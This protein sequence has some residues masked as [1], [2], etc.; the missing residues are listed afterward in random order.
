MDYEKQSGVK[1]S[2]TNHDATDISLHS[3]DQQQYR[4]SK[5]QNNLSSSSSNTSYTDTR[6]KYQRFID[7]FKPIDLEDDGID[8]SD[9]TPT[10]K[11]NLATSRH[12]LARR[13][14]SRH[15]Q[16][17]AIGGSIGTV[18]GSGYALSQGGP[19][20]LLLGYIIVGFVLLMVIYAL[21][22]MSVQWS[23][24][25]GSFNGHFT[26]LID[27]S[28]GYTLSLMY[29]VSWAVSYPSELIAAAMT[30][31]Y[32][33]DSINPA[34]WVAIIWVF[35]SS[36]NLF[37]VKG[38]GESEFFLSII[39]IISVI[40]FIILGIIIT[41][42]YGKQGYLGGKY[43]H[44][45]IANEEMGSFTTFKGFAAVFISSA[46]AF[47]GIELVAL[48]AAES[49][50]PKISLPRATKSTFWRLL[51][52]YVL[53]AVIIGCLVPYSN[54]ELLTGEGIAAS[55]F[56]IAVNLAG[57]KV[58]PHIMNAVIIISV[59]SVGSS[60]V[61]GSSR[62]LA[63]MAS[64]GLIFSWFGYVDR[65]GRPLVAIV[66]TSLIG[67]LGFL[68]VNKN[69]EEVFTWFFSVCSL[70]AFFTWFMIS[71]CHI[72]FRLALSK[73]GRGTDEIIFKSPFGMIGSY[74]A[75]AI[76]LFII[77]VVIW[78][79]IMPIGETGADVTTFFQ[80]CLSLPLLLIIWAAHKT[81]TKTWNHLW[82]KLENVDLDTGRREV[83][84]EVLRQELAE[85]R[86]ALSK[87]PIWYKVY[88]FLC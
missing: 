35:C 42:G 71:V 19:G 59:I 23:N 49:E 81:Y 2:S 54:D 85:E 24:T 87:K 52:F 27:P 41:C 31:Q 14:K 65:E 74:S 70:S 6:K 34:A 67:L 57:I 28:W 56:V 44:P 66:L 86:E 40:G 4:S 53:T 84:L 32:W 82:V 39:K 15:L 25:S 50:N 3:S 22:E 64:Q 77:A 68:V 30:I 10:E 18:V 83:N 45:A 63:S 80:N 36:I 55:P 37:G 75:M 16:M 72:R 21:G 51:L 12:P 26:R 5:I 61:Y 7:S 20:S 33:N 69:E 8:V 13:L 38:Y 58:I 76:L 17:I 48:A 79:G 47:G 78:V 9:L 29:Y 88:R 62:T 46:F 73:Q 1:T 11:S 60:S 43:W